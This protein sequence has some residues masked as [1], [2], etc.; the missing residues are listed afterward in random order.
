MAPPRPPAYKSQPVL[1]NHFLSITLPPTEF[2][3]CLDIKDCGTGSSLEPPWN[4]TKQ[5]QCR[6]AAQYTSVGKRLAISLIVL[7]S[8][9][10]WD[11]VIITQQGHDGDRSPN[12]QS[13][14]SE[15]AQGV[16]SF[17]SLACV[18]MRALLLLSVFLS[19]SY[20][21]WAMLLT[22][23]SMPTH[24]T[25]PC[26]TTYKSSYLFCQLDLLI[27][28]TPIQLPDPPSVFLPHSD[29]WH[30]LPA[31]LRWQVTTTPRLSLGVGLEPITAHAHLLPGFGAIPMSW[32]SCSWGLKF[33]SGLEH[34][35]LTGLQQ[36][37]S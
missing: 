27:G 5:F 24:H 3:L 26:W 7:S 32:W 4:A 12:S 36:A 13:K 37:D 33:T 19:S 16:G 14:V 10:G 6:V 22:S 28:V 34:R 35:C 17:G 25:H 9:R 2:F 29:G 11:L 30:C 31:H 1:G 23:V 8:E 21:S 18:W 20:L 15:K